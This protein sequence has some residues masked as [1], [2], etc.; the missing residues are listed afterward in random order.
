MKKQILFYILFINL[1]FF[2]FLFSENSETL[3][4]SGK[5][6]KKEISGLS[7]PKKTNLPK[8]T[9]FPFPKSRPIEKLLSNQSFSPSFRTQKPVRIE[10]PKLKFQPSTQLPIFALPPGPPI[11]RDE[12][13]LAYPASPEFYPDFSVGNANWAKDI[14]GSFV[15]FMEAFNTS[16][17]LQKKSASNRLFNTLHEEAL[18]TTF[19][20]HTLAKV[21]LEGV[22]LQEPKVR[23]QGP[24]V[25]I[26][27][28]IQISEVP[29]DP[30]LSH[31]SEYSLKG[32]QIPNY[33]PDHSPTIQT[34]PIEIAPLSYAL[35]LSFQNLIYPTSIAIHV[36][37][38]SMNPC[39][40]YKPIPFYFMPKFQTNSHISHDHAFAQ[41]LHS[42]IATKTLS[43]SS[44]FAHTESPH[45]REKTPFGKL[46][47][48]IERETNL[49]IARSPIDMLHP[50]LH[51]QQLI[52]LTPKSKLIPT[53][54]Y[55]KDN[56]QRTNRD[57]RLT[58]Y[59][60]ALLPKPEDLA[61]DSLGDEFKVHVKVIPQMTKKGYIF[62]LNLLPINQEGLDSLPHNVIF[63][64]DQGTAIEK[65][66]FETYKAAIIQSLNQLDENTSF[67][68]LSFDQQIQPLSTTMLRATAASKKMARQYL[69][70]TIQK[71]PSTFP[72]LFEALQQL[73]KHAQS[74][75]ELYTLVFLS[76]G[77]VMKNI[78]IHREALGELIKDAPDNLSIFTASIS[79]NN[80]VGM[81][82]LLAKLGKGELFHSQTNASFPRKL[83]V[84]IKRLNKPIAN[85]ICITNLS[86][87]VKIFQNKNYAPILFAD[88]LYTFYGTTESLEDIDLIIQGYRGERFINIHKKISLQDSRRGNGSYEKEIALHRAF[89]HMVDFLNTNDH[90]DLYQAQLLLHPFDYPFP[91]P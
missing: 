12:L 8:I 60:L 1:T 45:F 47:P 43:S 79:D 76:N 4:H 72:T 69:T 48:K 65:Y 5:G 21:S 78:R 62:T 31:V 44:L 82:E 58:G 88:K 7:F 84:L 18:P 71:R 14:T 51:Y 9:L 53:Q 56:A 85:N 74:S 63:L 91:A 29:F 32:R 73:K 38:P 77:H 83:S 42:K 40:L 6:L 23:L 61:T 33:Y 15:Y 27:P 67:N 81:L 59:H 3:A 64:L 52:V 54:F 75:K 68:I 35:N 50:L 70:K 80:N 22:Q 87:K 90:N 10:K 57:L 34:E 49:A 55:N 36:G 11:T 39:Q 24:R 37:T 17:I 16:L 13:S 20:L 25:H 2:T 41:A 86:P 46:P 19:F 66:R 28:Q 30:T 89:N 26:Q